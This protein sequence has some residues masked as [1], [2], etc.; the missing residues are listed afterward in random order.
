MKTHELAAILLNQD[1]AAEVFVACPE[2]EGSWDVPQVLKTKDGQVVLAID[3]QTGPT[4]PDPEREPGTVLPDG[5]E[6]IREVLTPHRRPLNF[7]M[8]L[9]VYQVEE[10][11]AAVGKTFQLRIGWERAIPGQFEVQARLEPVSQ[12]LA[13]MMAGFEGT[14]RPEGGTD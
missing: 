12:F 13:V 5:K 6:S 2:T 1:P 7:T 11:M 9:D 14:R 3:K 4:V 10:L 8:S